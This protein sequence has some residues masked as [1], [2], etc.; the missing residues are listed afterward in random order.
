MNSR[1]KL[2]IALG[3]SALA[4]P[5]IAFAQQQPKVWRIGLL[6]EREQS[7]ATSVERVDAFK[8]GM[9]ELGYAEGKHYVIE[10][11][12][13][14]NNYTRLS[15]LVA[16]L[17]AVKVDM[18]IASGT[19]SALAARSATRETPILIATVSDPVG[20]G[21]VATLARPGGNVTGLTQDVDKDLYSKRLDLLREIVSG[22]RRAGFLY[23]PD[24]RSDARTLKQFESDCAKLGFKSV[25]APVRS[26]QEIATAFDKLKLDRAQGLIVSGAGTN[27][28][29]REGI[30]E[31]AANHRLPTVYGGSFN[32]DS[33]GL[34]SYAANLLDLY[35]RAAAYA[36]K[37]F[38]GAKPGDLPIEQPTQFELVINSKTAKALGIKIPDSIMLQATRVVR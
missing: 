26:A 18:I 11:R 34:I 4:V 21:L 23:N 3:A 24:N 7:D 14:Q 19:P 20:S 25:R 31:Q 16:E 28:A 38:K 30:I 29:W 1:R 17:L 36:D 33:G 13:A 32:V 5:L 10:P 22:L 12:S 35:R 37:I 2:I 15:A 8:R 27:T 9:R 6:W